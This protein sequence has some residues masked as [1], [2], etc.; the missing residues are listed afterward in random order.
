M[1]SNNRFLSKFPFLSST[2]RGQYQLLTQLFHILEHFQMSIPGITLLA[3]NVLLTGCQGTVL[4]GTTLSGVLGGRV[5]RWSKARVYLPV[6]YAIGSCIL[7]VSSGEAGALPESAR[8]ISK[9]LALLMSLVGILFRVPISPAAAY[10]NL[11]SPFASWLCYCKCHALPPPPLVEKGSGGTDGILHEV[12]SH[13]LYH[14]ISISGSL[15]VF[16]VCNDLMQLPLSCIRSPPPFSSSR[17]QSFIPCATTFSFPGLRK[18]HLQ[19]THRS[20]SSSPPQARIA[21]FR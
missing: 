8:I 4:V 14:L 7:L 1:K 11:K 15:F 17:L 21:T 5:M 20:Y 16:R 18:R 10:C 6:S 3:L 13:P 9:S 12:C 2:A 19:S